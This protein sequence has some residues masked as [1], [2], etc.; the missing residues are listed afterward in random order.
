MTASILAK[1]KEESR[2]KD[3]ITDGVGELARIESLD[4]F[5]MTKS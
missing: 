5:L 3:R 1:Y 2:F 4:R